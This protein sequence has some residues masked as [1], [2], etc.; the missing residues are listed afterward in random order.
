MISCLAGK[1]IRHMME[2]GS[3]LTA[4]LEQTALCIS[5]ERVDRFLEIYS[6]ILFFK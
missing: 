1:A 4:L 5:H 6:Q 2:S 3:E